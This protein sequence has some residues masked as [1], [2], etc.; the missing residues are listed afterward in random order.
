MKMVD[1]RTEEQKERLTAVVIA[2]DSWMS[3]WGGAQGGASYAGW[4]CRP[5]DADEVFDWVVA[6]SEMKGVEIAAGNFRPED[7]DCV[8]CHIYAVESGHPAL[9]GE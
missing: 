9:T 6:R 3:G 7:P 5:E 2:R 4:A 8:H 1:D